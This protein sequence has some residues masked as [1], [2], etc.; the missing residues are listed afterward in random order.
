M[1]P[2]SS[3]LAAASMVAFASLVACNQAGGGC[4]YETWRGTCALRGVRTSK[5]IERFPQSFVLVEATYEPV[6]QGNEFAP[7]PFRKEVLAPAQFEADLTAHLR[8]QE[9]INCAVDNPVGDPCAPKMM[10]SIQ[11]YVPPSTPP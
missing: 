9:T 4:H 6:S 7:P 1:K 10:A 2:S 8:K 3:L 11:E 5:V